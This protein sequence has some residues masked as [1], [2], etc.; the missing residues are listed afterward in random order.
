MV[1]KWNM[2][3]GQEVVELVKAELITLHLLGLLESMPLPATQGLQA[4]KLI[5]ILNG[6]IHVFCFSIFVSS[7]D[8]IRTATHSV[9][10]WY[11]LLLPD[12]F[13]CFHVHMLTTS[14]FALFTY[15]ANQSF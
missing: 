14:S 3:A 4:I 11:I 9:S 5:M 15:H 7:Y 1:T 13:I 12:Y 8:L 2:S 6:L 10:I